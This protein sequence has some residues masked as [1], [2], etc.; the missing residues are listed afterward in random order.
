MCPNLLTILK[1]NPFI[2]H[3]NTTGM[4]LRGTDLR[5]LSPRERVDNLQLMIFLRFVIIT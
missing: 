4:D 3:F 5:L 2:N 1:M